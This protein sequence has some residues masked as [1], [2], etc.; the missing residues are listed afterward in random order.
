MDFVRTPAAGIV[1]LRVYLNDLVTGKL[2]SE[3]SIAIG[4]LG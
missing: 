2:M 4:D 1:S 3:V